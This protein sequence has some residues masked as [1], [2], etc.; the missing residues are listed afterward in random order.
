MEGRGAKERRREGRSQRARAQG[1]GRDQCLCPLAVGAN[2][3]PTEPYCEVPEGT[4]GYR[5]TLAV[6]H[7]VS[8]C[9]G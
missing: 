8:T 7:Y 1:H 6:C 4:G 5:P 3:K 2:A 9:C